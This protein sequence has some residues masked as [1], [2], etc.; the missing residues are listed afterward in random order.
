MLA[1]LKYRIIDTGLPKKSP[2][3]MKQYLGPLLESVPKNVQ[4][5]ASNIPLIKGEPLIGFCAGGGTER[6]FL[7]MAEQYPENPA[8]ILVHKKSNSFAAGC[9]ISAR[10]NA[11]FKAGKRAP[12]IFCCVDD[13]ERLVPILTAASTASVFAQK[14]PKIGLIGNP[15]DWLIG[16]GYYAEGLPPKFHMHT[17]RIDISEFLTGAKKEN[18]YN[19]INE[20]IKKHKLDAFTIRCFDLVTSLKCTS[21][22]E[23]SRFND[24][25]MTAACEGDIPATVT[26]MIMN[27]MTGS[28]IFMANPTGIDGTTARFAHCTIP[29]KLT[30]SSKV[31]THFESG[32]GTSVAGKVIEGTWTAARFGVNGD[33]M[34]T[35]CEVTNPEKPSPDQCR[36]QIIAKVSKEFAERLR[37]GDVLGNHFLFVPGNI[38]EALK[39]YS[40]YFRNWS[41]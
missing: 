7:Q 32:I 18:V 25:G 14:K 30:T 24:E 28:P 34:T 1:T 31:T 21:C 11:D 9:E 15:S 20:I 35:S 22:L 27:Q 16:S 8:V 10:L 5:Q 41:K 12:S 39:I 17:E 13:K 2:E 26:M 3:L 40:Q 29:R 6:M 4:L 23:V 38:A 19:S 33:V 37:T 36:T